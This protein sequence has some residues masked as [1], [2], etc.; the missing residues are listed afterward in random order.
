MAATV[1]GYN[2]YISLLELLIA[3]NGKYHNQRT[4]EDSKESGGEQ[5]CFQITVL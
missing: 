3:V 4:V 5:R 1:G 2:R